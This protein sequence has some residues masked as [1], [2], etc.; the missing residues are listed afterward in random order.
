MALGVPEEGWVVTVAATAAGAMVERMA[1]GE[2]AGIPEVE[3]KAV[4]MVVAT[5][6]VT[7]AVKEEEG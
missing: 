6:V 3:S 5:A 7:V 4:A 1:A 2:S